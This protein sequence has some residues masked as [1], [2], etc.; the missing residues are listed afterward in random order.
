MAEHA[1]R[2]LMGH[3]ARKGIALEGADLYVTTFPCP[4]CAHQIVTAGIRRI[5]YR[6]GYSLV[7]ASETLK[8]H[9]IE[10]IRVVETV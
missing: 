9:G 1:E 6:D 4:G 10:V 2:H 3:A 7:E 5:F 8:H